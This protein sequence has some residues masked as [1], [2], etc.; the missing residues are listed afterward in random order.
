MIM[1]GAYNFNTLKDLIDM[2]HRMYNSST[3]NEKTFSGK[4]NQLVELYMQQEG[5]HHYV[6]NLMLFLM[7]VREKYVKLYERFIEEL[8]SYSKVI[9]VL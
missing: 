1:Y 5:V 4:F 7:T 3:W 6:I 8:K 2:E 9:R